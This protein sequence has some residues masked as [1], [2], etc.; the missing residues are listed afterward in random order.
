M[1]NAIVN[2]Y[3]HEIL[4]ANGSAGD[5]GLCHLVSRAHE[6]R[7]R[8]NHRQGGQVPRGAGIG[9]QGNERIERDKYYQRIESIVD[10]MA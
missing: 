9:Q 4:I 8:E 10:G 3:Y 7:G 6:R 5:R 1:I 2:R